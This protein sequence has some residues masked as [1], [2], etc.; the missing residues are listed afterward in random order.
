[1]EADADAIVVDTSHLEMRPLA[2]CDEADLAKLFAD[3][4]AMRNQCRVATREE[5]RAYIA[6]HEECYARNGFGQ[7]A[8][9]ERD[10]GAFIGKCGFSSHQIDGYREFILSHVI[11]P[12]READDYD[13]EA[14]GAMIDYAFNDLDFMRVVSIAKPSN[15]RIRKV[16]E[17]LGM[18]SEKRVEWEGQAYCLYVIHN[19]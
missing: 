19:G 2:A 15:R 18:E 16:L 11:D 9:I 10:S 7:L 8:I 1:M 17:A 12:A 14:L 3:E 6:Q 13:R 4:K 5:A